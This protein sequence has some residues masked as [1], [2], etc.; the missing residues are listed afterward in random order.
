MSDLLSHASE[1]VT[2]PLPNCDKIPHS[3]PKA[4]QQKTMD[5]SAFGNKNQICWYKMRSEI[6][7]L[8]HWLLRRLSR[9][10]PLHRRED[11]R[12]ILSFFPSTDVTSTVVSLWSSLQLLFII[13]RKH[14]RQHCQ[15]HHH[16]HRLRG[17]FL[18]R[19]SPEEPPSISSHR[20]R[21]IC[22]DCSAHHVIHVKSER[23]TINEVFSRYS[24]LF[25]ENCPWGQ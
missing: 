14:H 9:H 2:H 15:H 23:E 25:C 24:F 22:N 8:T 7:R 4:V 5:A 16:H 13:F 17:I 19:N 11:F 6:I 3:R 18:K 1:W 10:G 20:T 12:A 21:K